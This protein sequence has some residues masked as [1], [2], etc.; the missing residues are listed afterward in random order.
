MSNLPYPGHS[1]STAPDLH[2][3]APT[4]FIE[5][6]GITYAYRIFGKKTGLPLVFL[7]HLTATID[8]WDPLV[9]NGLAQDFQVVLFDNKGVGASGGET[10]DYIKAMADDATTFIKALGFNKVHLIAFSLGGFVAQQMAIDTPELIGKVIL[11]GTGPKG[12]EGLDHIPQLL[13]KAF[14]TAPEDPR[15]FLFY[16]ATVNSRTLGLDSLARIKKRTENRV[17]N[18][19]MPSIQ[20][21]LK[22]ILGWGEPDNNELNKLKEILHPVLIINGSNDIMV[23]TINSYRLFQGLPNA[24]LNLYPDSG[25]GAIFQYPELFVTEATAFLKT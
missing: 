13:T 8:D 10:P 4:Q 12:S 7:H 25:H 9:T 24:W 21:Q 15:L 17:P 6:D 11:A 19:A 5:I 14:A 3:T 22:S 23:P 2:S 16:N 20:A 1:L 18:T